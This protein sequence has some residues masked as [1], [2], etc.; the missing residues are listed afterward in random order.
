MYYTAVHAFIACLIHEH[1]QM[2]ACNTTCTHHE[3]EG[4]NGVLAMAG[5]PD[6]RASHAMQPRG[7]SNGR[8]SMKDAGQ[9]L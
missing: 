3:E 5:D 8:I 2:P 1:L 9:Q 7:C 6:W 4:C